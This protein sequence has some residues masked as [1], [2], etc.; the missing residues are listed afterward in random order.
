MSRS[1]KHHQLLNG[2]AGIGSRIAF[3]PEEA[4]I[5]TGRSRSRIFQAIKNGELQARKDGR[6]TILT[7]A[8]LSR[9]VEAMPTV[10]R[11]AS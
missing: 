2:V 3:S 5:V 11:S 7:S 9:W 1:E 4:A 8:E 6:A 10:G